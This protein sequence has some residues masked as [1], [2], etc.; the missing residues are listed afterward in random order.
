M[1]NNGKIYVR[2]SDGFMVEWNRE[3]IVK[4]LL[5]DTLLAE[6]FHGVPRISEREAEEIAL[7]AER[8]IR[9]MK[10]EFVSGPLIREVVNNILL[11]KS[12]KD[13]RYAV[14]RNVHTRVGMPVSDAYEIDMGRGFEA[15]ENANLQP[16]PE[17]SHK[18]KA[19]WVSKEEYLLLIPPK[20]ADA[21]LS[22]DIHIHDLEYFG[23]RPFCQ[24][25][26]LRFVFYYGF[27]PDGI[28]LRASVA[29]PAKHPEVAILHAAKILAAGQT[30]FSGG[31]GFY[32]FLVFLAP[33]MRGL[34]YKQ[35]KQMMQMFVYEMSQMYVARGGQL[36][37][38]NVQIQVGVPEIWRDAPAV[39]K[40]RVGPDVYGD[41]EDEVQ[42]MFR[43]LC[44]VA[45]EGDALGKPFSFPKLEFELSPEFFKDEYE[46]LWLKVHEVV[47]KNGSPYF[48]NV[49]PDYRGYGKGV[50]C[51]QCCAFCF[52]ET[53][54][55]SE[56]FYEK[57][58]FEGGK[59]F[60]MGGKQV[61]SLNL[62]R[63]AYKANGDDEKLVEEVLRMMDLAVEVFKVKEKWLKLAVEHN[64]LPFATQRPPDPNNGGR[65]PPLVDLSGLVYT[66]GVIGGN[67][68]AQHH[69]GYQLH[70]SPEAVKLLVRV[71]LEMLSLIHI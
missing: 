16:N 51:Y 2:R 62:P 68:M 3:Y 40:G 26:D 54:K 24:N 17:T 45:L 13:P 21:H 10:L 59:H 70:E 35:I 52:V 58:Y 49:I 14:Y 25:Y 5:R 63:A 6:M 29:K 66:I 57:L 60:S 27:Y 20:L 7:E 9:A 19:D 22:G 46:D 23:T 61:V 41:F 30:N 44:E 39:A 56:D 50:S 64:R 65:A 33:Y 36:V 55:T 12:L 18:K 34:S 53:E 69:T 48:D 43:A 71:L 47:A 1:P 4:R 28:G 8:R 32:N 37:F 42:M 31:Q 15:K 67:E 38:S 11:E